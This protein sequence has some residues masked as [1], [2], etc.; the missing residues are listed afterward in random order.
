MDWYEENKK[1]IKYEE[2]LKNI[3]MRPTIYVYRTLI[4][5]LLTLAP[6]IPYPV[7][8]TALNAAKQKTLLEIGYHLSEDE[9]TEVDRM[10]S[11]I[12]ESIRGRSK[13]DS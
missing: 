6:H 13:P 7:F 2:A 11:E 10:V 5:S 1:N 8:E 9:K 12:L 3:G 4:V